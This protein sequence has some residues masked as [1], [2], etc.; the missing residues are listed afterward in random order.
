MLIIPM[1]N[2][3]SF[4]FCSHHSSSHHMNISWHDV[5]IMWFI[6][7]NIC[8]FAAHNRRTLRRQTSATCWCRLCLRIYFSHDTTSYHVR[9]SRLSMTTWWHTTFAQL[10]RNIMFLA[11][12]RLHELERRLRALSRRWDRRRRN[13][14]TRWSRRPADPVK[15][16]WLC[17]M[18]CS[19]L[20]HGLHDMKGV[21]CFIV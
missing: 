8:G 1:L 19:Q 10:R 15:S 3:L 16:A 12:G 6:C 20:S 14:P 11:L 5:L 13:H 2:L 17:C 4:Q 7:S 21:C 9:I 18:T